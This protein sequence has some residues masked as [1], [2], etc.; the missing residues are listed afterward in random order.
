VNRLAACQVA[1]RLMHTFD[2]KSHLLANGEWCRVV[3]DAKGEQ[4]H[5]RKT[6]GN[7][8]GR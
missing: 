8:G 3:V 5:A 1:K 2:M 4:R 7:G 6:V